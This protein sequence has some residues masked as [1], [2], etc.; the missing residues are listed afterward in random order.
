MYKKRKQLGRGLS[1][2]LGDGAKELADFS[3]SKTDRT[4]AIAQL[5][6]C[7]FQPRRNFAD[8]QIAELSQS[9]R[10]KGILQPLVVRPKPGSD[11][12]E[13]ICGERRW[14]AAQMASVHH[15]PVV[16]RDLTDQEALEIALIENLQR[17]DLLALEEAAAYQRLM[18]EFDHTQDA[19][20]QSIGKSRSHVANMVRLLNLPDGVKA[21][22]ADGR[23]SAGHGRALLGAKNPA[24]LAA[25]VVKNGLNVRATEALVRRKGETKPSKP[26]TVAP[27]DADTLSL[28]RELT[29]ALGLKTK[30]HAKGAGGEIRFS[31]ASL[32][33]LDGLIARL[34]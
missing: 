18:A 3:S 8:V 32:D 11:G 5:T 24:D 1:A 25:T 29:D 23:L 13:I 22:L 2:L 6:P 4:V 10:E 26:A 9:I 7:P 27:K 15:V 30:I 20:A 17:E 12:Y 16:V 34:R 31:Y 19:M 14:R 21:M 33:E 28:E